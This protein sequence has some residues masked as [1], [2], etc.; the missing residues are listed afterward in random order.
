M[1]KNRQMCPH[2]TD[3]KESIR[4]K[5]KFLLVTSCRIFKQLGQN[6]WQFISSLLI[7]YSLSPLCARLR[8][9]KDITHD[10]LSTLKCMKMNKSPMALHA[11]YPHRNMF[12]EEKKKFNSQ[13]CKGLHQSFSWEK[14]CCQF[15]S[16]DIGGES[17]DKES[18]K[19]EVINVTH[20]V[21]SW[22]MCHLFCRNFNCNPELLMVQYVIIGLA[23]L[24]GSYIR[25]AKS[26][27]ILLL[28]DLNICG[29]K[30]V[31]LGIFCV[32]HKR[33]KNVQM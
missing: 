8:C 23:I 13:E 16:T 17:I 22:H 19:R 21:V 25:K 14:S 33:F 20:L 18:L 2:T 30:Y 27:R 11:L 31:N 7:I 12:R 29:K 26:L 1:V 4:W 32:N 10:M 5:G 15:V 9:V 3:E 28:S 24:Y 6:F